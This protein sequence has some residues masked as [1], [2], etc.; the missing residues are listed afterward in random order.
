MTSTECAHMRMKT[1]AQELKDAEKLPPGHYDLQRA[2]KALEREYELCYEIELKW[3]KRLRR[4]HPRHCLLSVPEAQTLC[5]KILVELGDFRSV[6]VVR[7]LTAC[8]KL[9]NVG[10]FCD[11]QKKILCFCWNTIHFCVL[12]HEL[13]H[14]ATNESHHKKE[15]CEML[16]FIFSVAYPLY[17][18]KK[19][20][21]DWNIH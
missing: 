11:F 5:E 21:A 13:T 14:F 2:R 9:G 20:K 7:D 3:H 17:T 12:V 10:G 18:G 15:F 1:L 16:E 6:K 19:C 8:D 4:N